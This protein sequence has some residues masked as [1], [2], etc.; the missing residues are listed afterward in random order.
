MRVLINTS[1]SRHGFTG[2]TWLSVWVNASSLTPAGYA[3]AGAMYRLFYLQGV[4]LPGKE[5]GIVVSLFVDCLQAFGEQL[6]LNDVE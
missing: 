1:V 4:S 6:K 5:R 2:F 3:Q